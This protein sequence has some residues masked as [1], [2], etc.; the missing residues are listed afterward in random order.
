MRNPDWFGDGT[1]L[2]L[3]ADISARGLARL[4]ADAFL[5]GGHEIGV[6][7]PFKK[8]IFAPLASRLFIYK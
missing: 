7:E 1:P 4:D 3:L 8:A 6:M 2:A 5:S